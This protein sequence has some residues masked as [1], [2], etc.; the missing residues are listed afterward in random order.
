MPRKLVLVDSIVSRADAR[1]PAFHCSW[2]SGALDA[3]WVNVA[4]ELDMATTPQLE[5]VLR[6][7]ELQVRLVVLDLREVAF[8]DRSGVHA[9]VDASL[10]ARQVDHRLF[11]LR[12]SPGVD[13]VFT[14]TGSS[15]EVLDR[16][17]LSVEPSVEALVALVG[18]GVA[19]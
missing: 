10:R 2:T 15:D 19:P 17:I 18:E 4:G 11:L 9:I 7:P 3:A 6:E 5:E 13:R 1:P 14:I 8:M 16:D 12:G